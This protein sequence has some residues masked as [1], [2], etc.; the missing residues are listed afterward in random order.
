[1]SNTSKPVAK[2][3]MFP[4]NAA[5][6]RNE[7]NGRAYYSATF[8][9]SYRDDA[10]NW[11]STNSF[12]P[13]ICCFWRKSPTKLIRRLRGSRPVT[14]R[15]SSPKN[16]QHNRRPGQGALAS[17]LPL[18]FSCHHSRYRL[19]KHRDP[20][21][22]SAPVISPFQLGSRDDRN[23]YDRA[24]R[25]SVDGSS[26]R[27]G[28]HETRHP[29]FEGE[30]RDDAR[31]DRRPH[32]VVGATPEQ[33]SEPG[34]A[35]RTHRA[36]AGFARPSADVNQD[37]DRYRQQIEARLSI[38]GLTSSPAAQIDQKLERI[39]SWNSAIVTQVNHSERGIQI[40]IES[41]LILRFVFRMNR[42]STSG[43]KLCASRTRHAM[44]DALD[45]RRMAPTWQ[46]RGEPLPLHPSPCAAASRRH[47]EP[48]PGS[49]PPEVR[50]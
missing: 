43:S 34:S 6:W 19:P 50:P 28:R 25:G 27:P 39:P 35:H 42:R 49:T 23:H 44:N 9:R 21:P 22:K 14:A 1:M 3:Q 29:R 46:G 8:E 31:H 7:N 10:G 37:S 24:R 5:I 16:R 47:L 17:A 41:G 36:P 48:V 11:K 38:D 30:H 4:I 2:V 18:F 26:H 13:R 40:H 15:L 33:L 32:T 12:R 20:E 45:A